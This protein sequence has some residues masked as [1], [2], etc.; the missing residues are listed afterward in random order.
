[1]HWRP[2][3]DSPLDAIR[4]P[5]QDAGRSRAVVAAL[6]GLLRGWL[7]GSPGSGQP[8]RVGLFGGLGQGKSSAVCCATEHVLAEASWQFNLRQHIN[9]RRVAVFNVSHF[10]AKDLEWR[11][12]AAVLLRRCARNVLLLT[13]WSLIALLFWQST[14]VSMFG[15]GW[16]VQASAFVTDASRRWLPNWLWQLDASW[17]LG[18]AAIAGIAAFVWAR[19]SG[20]E[21]HTGTRDQII[22]RL[23]HLLGAEPSVLV[24]DD[25]D[26]AAVEQQKAFLRALMRFS[27]GLHCGVIVC[28]D[29]AA[30][31]RSLPDP[32]SPEQLLRKTLNL[33][34]RIPDRGREDV[35]ALVLSAC[36][37]ACVANPALERR[38]LRQVQWLGDLVRALMLFGPV[39]DISPRLVK[40]VLNDVGQAA[41]QFAWRSTPPSR[42]SAADAEGPSVVPDLDDWC[43]LL[44]LE[45]LYRLVP[46]LRR[47]AQSVQRAL[48]A[49]RGEVFE[50]ML[51]AFE[52]QGA[53]RQQALL[54]LNG[55]RMMQPAGEHGWFK[56]LCGVALTPPPES[57][58]WLEDTGPVL[59]L[60]T[61][62]TDGVH[63][64]TRYCTEALEWSIR[65]YGAAWGPTDRW[66][67]GDEFRIN[68]PAAVA[69]LRVGGPLGFGAGPTLPDTWCHPMPDEASSPVWGHE[70][71][72]WIAVDSSLPNNRRSEAIEQMRRWAAHAPKPVHGMLEPLID[73]EHMAD[74]SAWRETQVEHRQALCLRDP[75]GAR[76]ATVPMEARDL[77]M[78]ILALSVARTLPRRPA[79]HMLEPHGRIEALEHFTGTPTPSQSSQADNRQVLARLW[80]PLTVPGEVPLEAS[81]IPRLPFAAVLRSIGWQDVVP[82]SWLKVWSRLG[83]TQLSTFA[84]LNFLLGVA[85]T[86]L[87]EGG[88]SGWK[89]AALRPWLACDP[90]PESL[91][92][93]QRNCADWEGWNEGWPNEVWLLAML[94]SAR[95][96]W[97]IDP[98]VVERVSGDAAGLRD[99]MEAALAQ[100]TASNEGLAPEQAISPA[101]MCAD[102]SDVLVRCLS[103]CL[104]HLDSNSRVAWVRQLVPLLGGRIHAVMQRAG[105]PAVIVI[106]E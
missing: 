20:D 9:G 23:A 60:D 42:L 33:Q 28:M 90:W 8:L 59:L 98:E 36:R 83:R 22:H 61:Q 56:L 55:T 34:L 104:P 18:S 1:M 16:H 41:M 74:P 30:L 62:V 14:M 21:L 106:D 48:E 88:G 100:H 91:L 65:G 105:W 67:Q 76:L 43:A 97:K 71:L 32:E 81:S 26:R 53:A 5:A 31:L 87:I 38:V 58:D 75:G 11:L 29:E 24:V 6:G 82:D 89:L 49:N 68:S 95:Q 57:L 50:G 94:I 47:D 69:R 66:L 35:I 39:G 54:Y 72:C 19:F 103:I 93:L 92:L 79:L 44:R 7:F 46:A 86:P 27:Q 52:V 45:L 99:A 85:R 73:R 77:P 17:L 3:D 51:D 25:L 2:L 70:W 84:A 15:S 96:G 101:W 13:L 40:R 78:V 102:D 10:T 64:Y 37:L 80:P 12:F 4:L 63:A